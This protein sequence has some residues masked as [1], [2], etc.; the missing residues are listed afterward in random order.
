MAKRIVIALGG[1]LDELV[2]IRGS[3]EASSPAQA[4]QT[5]AA[6]AEAVKE[7]EVSGYT[8]SAPGKGEPADVEDAD[9]QDDD[10]DGSVP[11]SCPHKPG[12]VFR[13]GRHLLVCGDCTKPE[14]TKNFQRGGGKPI[15]D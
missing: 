4:D 8:R 3:E 7:I 5:I 14:I 12:D 11:E 1:S 10:Y 13:L 6:Y 15:S 9:A 2:G